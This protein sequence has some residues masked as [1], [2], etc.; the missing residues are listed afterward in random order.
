MAMAMAMAMA[1]VMAMV[2]AMAMTMVMAMVMAMAMAMAKVKDNMARAYMPTAKSHEWG[3]PQWLFDELNKEF[4]PFT[5]D[6][7]ATAENA[8]CD[9]FYTKEQ[10]GLEQS[11][12]G[13]TVFMNPPYGR[14]IAHWVKKAHEEWMIAAVTT[15]ALLPA[16][17]DTRWFHDHIC[18]KGPEIRFLKGRLRFGGAT[19]SAPFPSMVVI[20]R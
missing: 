4:G 12:A 14:E 15:V 2:M 8:K 6:P 3:T 9:K 10:N 5:L 1:L 17:T 7:C 19:N 11:W 20:W 16:R 13:E 18:K